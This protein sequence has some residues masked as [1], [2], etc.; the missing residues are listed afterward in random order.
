MTPDEWLAEQSSKM[1]LAGA[2]SH[3]A[4]RL[5]SE[6]AVELKA[7]ATA[8][9]KWKAATTRAEGLDAELRATRAALEHWKSQSRHEANK[10]ALEQNRD[11]RAELDRFNTILV[12]VAALVVGPVGGESHDIVER[13]AFAAFSAKQVAYREL[14]AELLSFIRVAYNDGGDDFVWEESDTS[15][16]L[17]GFVNRFHAIDGQVKP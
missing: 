8:A 9:L 6:H 3:E 11:L 17:D 16:R 12:E 15:K 7:V 5:L 10:L 4:S 1:L 2:L 13:V 14:C